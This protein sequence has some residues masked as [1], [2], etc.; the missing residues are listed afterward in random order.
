MY[1]GF[2]FYYCGLFFWSLFEKNIIK[3]DY[4]SANFHVNYSMIDCGNE[5]G[6]IIF[7][8]RPSFP[9]AFLFLLTDSLYFCVFQALPP[10]LVF[11]VEKSR[12]LKESF[13]FF[14][15]FRKRMF[16]FSSFK[17]SLCYS[18]YHDY[19]NVSLFTFFSH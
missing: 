6:M 1:Y 12:F 16:F 10:L 8:S 15:D 13:I 14:L 3:Q 4:N 17:L 11:F 2:I 7:F 9:L 18:C 19:Y 5:D